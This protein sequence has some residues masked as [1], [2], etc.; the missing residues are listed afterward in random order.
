MASFK[1]I[2]TK[3]VIGKGKKQFTDN[4][5]LQVTNT[6]NTILG[7][8]VINHNFSGT[9]SSGV[10]TINGSYDINIW[11]SYDN[12]TKTEV[13]K[14]TKNYIE[15][16]NVQGTDE[17]EN[18]EVIIRSLT[19]PSCSKAEINGS[20]INCTID[21]TLGIELVGDTKVRINTL[22]EVD[23]W[24]EIMDSDASIDERIDEE[25]NEEYLENPTE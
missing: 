12:D 7:C 10:V 14:D 9:F 1:E 17:T 19:G 15:T 8:W 25:I 11:Y 3:A 13:L 20:V 22:D 24:E 5:S 4:L 18:E 23:D 6:P 2:V 21:K 16:I